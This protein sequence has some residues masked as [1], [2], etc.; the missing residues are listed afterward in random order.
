MERTRQAATLVENEQWVQEQVP[1]DYQRIVDRI[2]SA[3]IS[4]LSDFKDDPS[5]STSSPISPV[6]PLTRFSTSSRNGDGENSANKTS[7]GTTKTPPVSQLNNDSN[8][9]IFVEERRFFVVGCSLS[10]IKIL[11]DYLRCMSNVP[12][13]TTDTMNRI[14]DIL[15]LF[16]SRTCQVIL[17]AGAMKSAGLKNITAKHLGTTY[18]F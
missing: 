17:G 14:V 2:V 6:F 13:L 16:N 11:G 5:D 1:I 12:T 7:N 3:A 4:G 9:Y 18:F 10:L 8:R 15:N